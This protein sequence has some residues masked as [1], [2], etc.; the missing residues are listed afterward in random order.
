MID[1]LERRIGHH[2]CRGEWDEMQP[3]NAF[4][5]RFLWRLGV[6]TQAVPSTPDAFLRE[7]EFTHDEPAS[8]A[9]TVGRQPKRGVFAPVLSSGFRE[10]RSNTRAG[11]SEPDRCDSAARAVGRL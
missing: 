10:W 1:L 5:P 9:V 11:S 6:E 8:S 7:F 2:R 3:W 4:S